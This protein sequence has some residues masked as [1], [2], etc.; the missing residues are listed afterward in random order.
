MRKVSIFTRSSLILVL[1]FFI[2]CNVI[3]IDSAYRSSDE[4]NTWAWCL[5]QLY[6]CPSSVLNGLSPI[7]TSSKA[8]PSPTLNPAGRYRVGRRYWFSEL[9][10]IN[11]LFMRREKA[12]SGNIIPW[13]KGQNWSRRLAQLFWSCW[14]CLYPIRVPGSTSNPSLLRTVAQVFGTLLP[15]WEIWVE[16]WSPGF[17]LAGSP[18]CG[19]S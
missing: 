15:T 7:S 13:K 10:I 5:P 8:R 16:F 2:F 6:F 18:E 11:V 1:F 17:S 3:L 14:R 12:D 4:T 9:Q 19:E